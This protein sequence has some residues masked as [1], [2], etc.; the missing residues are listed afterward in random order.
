MTVFNA[1][2]ATMSHMVKTVYFIFYYNVKIAK[3]RRC[4]Y[5]KYCKV[6]CK[7]IIRDI[8]CFSFF[9]FL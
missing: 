6:E 7:L 1:T 5:G 4:K 8:N 9:F 3:E 2:E